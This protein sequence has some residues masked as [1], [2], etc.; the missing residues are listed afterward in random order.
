MLLPL[1][2]SILAMTDTEPPAFFAANEELR[3]YVLEAGEH[4]PGLLAR[5]HEWRATLKRIPQAGALDDPML[6]YNH[7]LKSDTNDAR[8]ALTQRLPWFGTLR[9]RSDRAAAEA[10]AALARFYTARNAL[11]A[12]VKRAYFEYAFLGGR[13]EVV[14]AQMELLDFTE[15]IVRSK[16]SLGT[17][18]E[19]DLLRVQ[20]EET[21]V[22]DRL[23]GLV[24]MRPAL[25]A[26]LVETLGRSQ[27]EFLPWPQ[28]AVLP[29]A[30]PSATE[31]LERV[32]AL[33][34]ELAT[35]D[36]LLESRERS[37]RLARKKGRPD[38]TVGA[39]YTRRTD[40]GGED[41]LMTIVGVNLPSWRGRVKAGVE[42]ARLNEKATEYEKQRVTLSLESEVRITLAEMKDAARRFDLYEDT[43]IP[44]AERTYQSVQSA[45]ASGG[46]KADFLDLLS[47]VQVLLQFQI[48][49]LRA[50]RDL[51]LAA[52]AL[53]KTMSG[54]T[55]D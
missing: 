13:I 17:A 33:N 47:S 53:E 21:K 4:H 3:A 43:L 1:L 26:R 2:V 22:Q 51:Q 32:N 16:Y 37:V 44:K 41:F 30:P 19:A 31:A 11:F 29:P 6:T 25:S 54:W 49:Q 35:L 36:H 18:T 24:Q 14:R 52:A 55:S 9:A 10:D 7:F 27:A 39:G 38:F 23:D 45:Y 12:E 28:P 42:E 5:Y 20:I 50:E 15:D 34:P 48:D 40:M 46:P 8:A